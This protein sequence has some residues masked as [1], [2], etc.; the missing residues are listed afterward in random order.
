MKKK[1]DKVAYGTLTSQNVLRYTVHPYDSYD[2]KKDKAATGVK[3][4]TTLPK[5][6]ALAGLA[7]WESEPGSLFTDDDPDRN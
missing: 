2:V 3:L 5:E 6:F 4:R 1:N 7:G